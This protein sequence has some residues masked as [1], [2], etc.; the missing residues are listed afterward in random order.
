MPYKKIAFFIFV[1][2]L[3]FTINNLARSI[4]TTWQK[5]DL[6]T[7]TQ[8]DLVQAK[9]ENQDL[10]HKL[11]AVNQPEFIE[12]QARDKLLLAKPG[13]GVIVIPENTIIASPSATP[14]PPDTRPNW[15]KWWD[16][17]FTN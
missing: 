16:V 8:K 14:P 11:K 1:G 17:F 3:L 12:S 4:Y 7:K 13:E 10:R 15:K 6:I 5:Q 9:H 2:I